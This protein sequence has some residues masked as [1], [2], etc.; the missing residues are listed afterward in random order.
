MKKLTAIIL[1]L[2][3]MMGTS[4]FAFAEAD[5]TTP[6]AVTVYVTIV[7]KGAFEIAAMPIGVI[8][9][10]NDNAI[11][12]NDALYCAHEA[13]YPGAAAAG[14]GYAMTSYG[15][16]LTKLWGQTNNG[17]FGYYLDNNM[18]WSAADP[19][20]DGSNL[21]AFLYKDT[22]YWTD[23]FTFFDKPIV[24]AD[25][26]EV[27]LTLNSYAYDLEWN[28][29]TMPV[30]DAKI[31]VYFESNDT[32]VTDSEGKVTV[33]VTEEGYYSL[34]V[35]DTDCIVPA[36]CYMPASKTEAEV[37]AYT[38]ATCTETG[39]ATVNEVTITIPAKGH[40]PAEAVKESEVAATCTN[41]GCYNEVVYCSVCKEKISSELK[42]TEAKGHTPAEAVEENVTEAEFNKEGSYDSVV[43]CSECGEEISR[44]TVKIE[45][46]TGFVEAV[47]YVFA[48]VVNTFK[49]IINSIAGLFS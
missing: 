3:F 42:T 30:A 14:Y 8:D 18:C 15:L 27:E 26:E 45:A 33:P 47:K 46:K 22:I 32:Y 11:T 16:S 37:T 5:A 29:I 10:D 23:Q 28:L 48:K 40:N 12:V 13:F 21:V 2:I 25:G 34:H 41:S 7:N 39:S 36:L 44:E 31:D 35:E 1:A 4:V 17:G 20:T 9:I 49:S 38:A 24:S 19:V 43:Y 6:D